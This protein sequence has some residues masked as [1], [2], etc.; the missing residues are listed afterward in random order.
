MRIATWN[1]A[2]RKE[3]LYRWLDKCESKPDV[4]ALQKPWCDFPKKELESAGHKDYAIPR[5]ERWGGVAILSRHKARVVQD[6]LSGQEKLG[7]RFLTVEVNGL[8]ISSVYAPY[9][10]KANHTQVERGIGWLDALIDHVGRRV[11]DGQ[12]CVLCG[13]FNVSTENRGKTG[14][15]YTENDELRC[16]FSALLNLGFIDLYMHFPSDSRDRFTYN[17]RQGSF[18]LSKLQYLLGTCGVADRLRGAPTVD[19]DYRRPGVG[20]GS[21][22]WCP[23]VAD[24]DD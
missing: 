16:R 3:Y 24:L 2:H 11:F 20:N 7:S 13:D 15:R 18:K 23:L 22:W 8:K 1:F 21:R 4:V 19:I 9:G 17:G 12:Q 5:Y 10:D 6:G 14:G